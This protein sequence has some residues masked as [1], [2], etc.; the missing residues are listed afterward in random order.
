MGYQETGEDSSRFQK[1]SGPHR[2]ADTNVGYFKSWTQIPEI[3]DYL[4]RVKA[5]QKRI[6]NDI[7]GCEGM[8]G[9]LEP[10][11][12]FRVD[13]RGQEHMMV[14]FSW[15]DE[16]GRQFGC[17]ISFHQPF[18]DFKDELHRFIPMPESRNSSMNAAR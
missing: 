1:T 13:M 14:M 4:S 7:M 3:K 17:P 16:K 2:D 18:N 15:K 10:P 5:K 11:A 9:E 12:F 8:E 6:Y